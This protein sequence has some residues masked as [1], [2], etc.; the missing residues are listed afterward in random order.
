M[1]YAPTSYVVGT[2][3]LGAQNPLIRLA[4]TCGPKFLFELDCRHLFMHYLI[5]MHK[6]ILDKV[7]ACHYY[8]HDVSEKVNLH[9]VSMILDS[10]G[11]III[12]C[13]KTLCR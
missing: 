6:E 12:Y 9:V 5:L 10:L 13:T 7:S 2:G 3:D 4:L 1:Y 8:K 11:F